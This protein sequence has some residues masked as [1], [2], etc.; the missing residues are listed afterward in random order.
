MH[1]YVCIAGGETFDM[2]RD[3]PECGPKG[4]SGYGPVEFAQL[5]IEFRQHRKVRTNSHGSLNFISC[6]DK[7][8]DFLLILSFL[9]FLRFLE[10]FTTIYTSFAK[11]F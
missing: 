4:G 3:G 8:A 1:V 10:K 7:T 11:I 9:L 5:F 6:G 2:L